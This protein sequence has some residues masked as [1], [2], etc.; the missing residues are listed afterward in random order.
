MRGS[1]NTHVEGLILVPFVLLPLLVCLCGCSAKDAASRPIVSVGD[2]VLDYSDIISTLPPADNPDDSALY[3]NNFIRNWIHK[4]LIL[5]TAE[6]NILD[7]DESIDRLVEEFRSSLIVERYQQKL[8][9]Q[10]FIPKV[11]ESDLTNYYEQNKSDF[12]LR[13]SIVRGVY[14]VIPEHS[15]DTKSF[16]KILTSLDNSSS[17]NVEQ[18]L[19]KYSTSYRVFVDEWLSLSSISRFFPAGMLP[20][21]AKA[22]KSKNLFEFRYEGNIYLL[23]VIDLSL[24]NTTAPYEYVSTDIYNIIVGKQKADFIASVYK[25]L[26]DQAISDNTI[27]YYRNDEAKADK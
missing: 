5:Q 1:R 13:E 14:A 22:L 15:P 6:K 18:Y 2:C 12:V 11:T 8:I 27:K 10:K 7:A 25:N 17:L 24:A 23:K 21:D 4:Q 26:Y 19:F 16:I 20:D 9:E 3:A